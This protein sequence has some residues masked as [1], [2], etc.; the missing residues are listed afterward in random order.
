MAKISLSGLVPG[1]KYKIIIEADTGDYLIDAF[2]AIDFVVPKAPPHAKTSKLKIKKGN[3]LAQQGGKTV[4][5]P[6]L[7]L[8]IPQ[9]IISNL[10]F[11]EDVRDIVHIVYR[12]AANQSNITGIRKYLNGTT[13]NI[14]SPKAI[15][16]SGAWAKGHP[17]SF[18]IKIKGTN[19]YSFQFVIARYIKDS[20]GTWNGFWLQGNT[21]KDIISQ[22]AEWGS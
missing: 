16:T 12:S 8:T 18:T 7:S 4:K 13:F 20:N 21:L 10:I 3:Y 6:Q 19:Y 5:K 9:D 15:V 2:Q 22:Q 17:K 1:K 11:K 14:S